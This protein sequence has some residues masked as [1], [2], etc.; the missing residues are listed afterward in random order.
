MKRL[1]ISLVLLSVVSCAPKA[2]NGRSTAL[3]TQP[4]IQALQKTEVVKVLDIIRDTAVDAEAAKVLSTAT[5]RKIVQAHKSIIDVVRVS[6]AG[7][8]AVVLASLQQLK[9]N[10]TPDELAIVGPYIDAAASTI[11]AVIQ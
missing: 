4:G 7:W 9:Q 11:Q 1:L 2:V 10:L 3:L 5:T 6:G 8:K